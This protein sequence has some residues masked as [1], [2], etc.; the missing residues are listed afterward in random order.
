[1][2]ASPKAAEVMEKHGISAM[3]LID[4]HVHGDW[5][6]LNDEYKAQNELAVKDGSPVLSIYEP[7][8]GVTL[9]VI[10]DRV[11]DE[12]GHRHA[13]V[14]LLPEENEGNPDMGNSD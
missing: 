12:E 6:N 14:I 5:G 1:M 2:V 4:R 11:I 13:T 8:E 9:C 10:T 3:N 7:V